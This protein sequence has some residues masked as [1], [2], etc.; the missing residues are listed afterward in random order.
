MRRCWGCIS[1]IVDRTAGVYTQY[2]SIAHYSTDLDVLEGNPHEER[3][4]ALARQGDAE[5]GLE[6]HIG[7]RDGEGVRGLERLLHEEHARHD[8]LAAHLFVLACT[9]AWHP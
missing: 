7:E 8:R 3:L 5:H 1:L 2:K 9:C 6:L 4:L